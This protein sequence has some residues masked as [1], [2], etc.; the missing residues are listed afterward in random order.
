MSFEE[1]LEVTKIYSV[2]G[3]L[4]GPRP[5]LTERPFRAPHHTVSDAGLVGGGPLGGP[6]RSP[7]PTGA[8]CS[9]T[10]SRSSDATCSRCSSSPSRTA[11]CNARANHHVSYPA[12]VMLVAAM[13][14]CPCG[15][16]G[17]AD[18][19]CLCLR[20]RVLEY[21]PGERTAPRPDR[22]HRPHPTRRG[23]PACCPRPSRRSR[24]PTT[25]PGWRTPG[26]GSESDSV[27]S[28]GSTAT[29]RCRRGSSAS[30][31]GRRRRPRRCCGWR[32]TGMG[33][34]T[35]ARPH[36]EAGP[37]TGGPRRT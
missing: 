19:R 17:V 21:H 6:A 7:S 11:W 18:A 31:A 12:Q 28:Q 32:W 37:D 23:L 16:L 9:S 10:S 29:P 20:H 33:F 1:A 15:R 4:T 3:L 36:P 34:G 30:I 5:L 13:N 8:C 26:N 2:S 14:A 24:A 35:R 27:S 22:H 25:A